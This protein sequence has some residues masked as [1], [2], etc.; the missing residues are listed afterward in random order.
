MEGSNIFDY[1]HRQDQA[2]LADQLGINFFNNSSSPNSLD[3]EDG[4][5]SQESN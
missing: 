1:V 3:S 2:E 5:T 4:S